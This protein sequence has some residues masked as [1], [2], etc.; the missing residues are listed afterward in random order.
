MDKNIKNVH[1]FH[2]GFHVAVTENF[3]MGLFVLVKVHQINYFGFNFVTLPIFSRAL[4]I[5]Q[6]TYV[7]YLG[8]GYTLIRI[9]F[10]TSAS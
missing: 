6:N 9:F 7:R 3:I 5:Y 1:S 4:R 10:I 8:N 2:L